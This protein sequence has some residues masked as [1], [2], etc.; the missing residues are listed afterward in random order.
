MIKK[1]LFVSAALLVLFFLLNLPKSQQLIN[2]YIYFSPCDKPIEFRLGTISS[3]FKI[4]QSEFLNDIEEAADIWNNTYGKKLFSYN[5]KAVFPISL[6]Y[7]GRQGLS[8]DINNLN[9]Q[10]EKQNQALNPQVQEYQIRVKDFQNRVD[11]LNQ[12][13][14]YWNSHGGAP[15]D[16]YKKLTEEQRSLQQEAESLNAMAKSLNQSTTDYNS[17]VKTLNRDVSA[18][19]Q[20]LQ[21]KPEEE[22][23]A[24]TKDSRQ[25]IIYFDNTHKEF[26]HTI[27]HEMGHALGIAHNNNIRSIMYPRTNEVVVPSKDDL[28]SLAAVCQK[29]SIF[30]NLINNIKVLVQQLRTQ[31]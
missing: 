8:N 24:S 26:V 20:A 4:S 25:I 17:Q 3:Q 21:G 27:A 22:V 18:F 2:S 6:V 7:D 15:E 30:Q 23:Y 19:N 31:T 29:R 28:N 10:L 12:Q 11:K 5:A 13:V 16:Q 1:I 9:S 14:S